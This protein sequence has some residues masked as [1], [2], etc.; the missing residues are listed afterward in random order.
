MLHRWVRGIVLSVL[1]L[2]GAVPTNAHPR[3]PTERAWGKA[4]HLAHVKKEE[5]KKWT[6]PIVTINTTPRYSVISPTEGNRL[7]GTTDVFFEGPT[8]KEL[9][10][11]FYVS[12]FIHPEGEDDLLLSVLT[13]EFLHVVWMKRV[14]A[15]NAWYQAHQ[16]GEAWV[17]T[18]IPNDCPPF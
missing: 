17:R 7:C 13:H 18:L 15:N 16:D 11:V 10:L 3:S 14:I 8:P 9:H 5:W 2:L 1:L 6:K 4:M 12:V